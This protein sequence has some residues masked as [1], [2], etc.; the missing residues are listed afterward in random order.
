LIGVGS[1]AGLTFC[2]SVWRAR[3]LHQ[4]SELLLGST[5]FLTGLLNRRGFLAHVDAQVPFSGTLVLMDING[6]KTINDQHGHTVGDQEIQRL[7]EALQQHL[8]PQTLSSRWGGDEFLLLFPDQQA[9]VTQQQLETL[10]QQ[11]PSVIPALPLFSFG[12]AALT[13]GQ[14]FEQGFAIA[15][16]RLYRAKG[17]HQHSKTVEED[18]RG[19]LEFAQHLERLASPEAVIREGLALIRHRLRFDMASYVE[20]QNHRFVI[21]F[22]DYAGD[23]TPQMDV[24]GRLIEGERLLQQVVK[25]RGVVVSVDYPNDPAS[26]EDFVGL[27]VKSLVL[28]PVQIS[29]QVVGVLVLCH[30]ST[31]KAIPLLTQSMLELAA[32]RLAHT[33]EI[34]QAVMQVRLTLEGGLLALGVALEARDLETRGH[35][36]RVVDMVTQLAR[37]LQFSPRALD[38]LRQGAYL[39]DIGKLSIPDRILLKP[40]PLD[41][42]EWALMQT[43][44]QQGVDLARRIPNLSTGAIDVIRCHHERWDGRGYPAGLQGEAIPLA[45]RIFAVCDVYDALTSARPYKQ[46]WTPEAARA[47][48]ISQ[49]ARQFCPLVIDAFIA[50]MDGP[51]KFLS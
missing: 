13:S 41:P 24:V 48:I 18:D 46:A 19:L 30:I 10:Q 51:D 5:D 37:Q 26:L 47:E 32:S 50:M 45:A 7:A 23:F 33:L 11:L 38:E 16:H 29:G 15:D 28:A 20:V 9:S 49:R 12:L 25:G 35:T 4:D 2:I 43:H 27:G 14:T 31:W 42:D 3:W 22:A 17:E 40:G 36:E 1:V 8:P 21:L 34:H 39:H 44:V 6:L